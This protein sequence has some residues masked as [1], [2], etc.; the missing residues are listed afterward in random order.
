MSDYQRVDIPVTEDIL[1][2][3]I[4]DP[5]LDEDGNPILG[6]EWTV[7]VSDWTRPPSS[8]VRDVR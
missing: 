6:G 1:G 8:P 3:P 4:P 2:F 5:A 7:D